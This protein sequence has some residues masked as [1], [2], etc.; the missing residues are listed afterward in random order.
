[1]SLPRCSTPR[2]VRLAEVIQLL[3]QREF[4]RACLRCR[5]LPLP[6]ACRHRGGV[7]RRLRT[8]AC[9]GELARRNKCLW[10]GMTPVAPRFGMWPLNAAA[11]HE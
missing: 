5:A 2:L 8:Q 7:L 11:A 1:M 9:Q 4:K 10:P 3:V 6:R